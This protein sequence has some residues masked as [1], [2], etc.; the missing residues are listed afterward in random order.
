HH[1]IYVETEKTIGN[2]MLY[3]V[4]GNLLVGMRLE[5]KPAKDPRKSITGVSSQH[6]GWITAQNHDSDRMKEICSTVPPPAAQLNLNGSRLDPSK[7]IR[8]CQHWVAEVIGALKEEGILEP[9]GPTDDPSIQLRSD[10]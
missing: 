8:H 6:I 10:S 3:H 7:P 5:C 4:E 9:L 2:G 1:A